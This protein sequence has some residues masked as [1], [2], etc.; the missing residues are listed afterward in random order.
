VGWSAFFAIGHELQA[1]LCAQQLEQRASAGVSPGEP[2]WA[3]WQPQ[4]RFPLKNVVR[5]ARATIA[6]TMANM[7]QL[8]AFMV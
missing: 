5:M 7:I 6:T 1:A 8:A 3:P 2:S 4:L